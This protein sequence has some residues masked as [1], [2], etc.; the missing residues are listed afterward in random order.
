MVPWAK[1]KWTLPG[2]G[3]EFGEK[4]EDTVVREVQ[5][6]TGLIVRPRDLAAVDSLASENQLQFFHNIR[7]IYQ[8]ELLGGE[9]RFEQE[10]S[11]DFCQWLTLEEASDLPLV[12]LGK[13]GLQIFSTTG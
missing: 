1:G 13:V 7:I 12:Q 2:G 4:P 3:I 11:T 10:G 6:E 9:L 8:T 5:E